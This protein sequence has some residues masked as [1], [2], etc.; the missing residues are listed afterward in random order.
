MAGHSSLVAGRLISK[1][2]Y[3]WGLLSQDE[4]ISTFAHQNLKV[5]TEALMGFS[6]EHSPEGHNTTL[7]PQFCA[8]MAA[9]SPGRHSECPWQGQGR[10]SQEPLIAQVQ[11]SGQPFV[12]FP[13][14]P[15]PTAS[16][17]LI[18]TTTNSPP[19][20]HTSHTFH[21]GFFRPF[22]EQ[23]KSTWI[24]ISQHLGKC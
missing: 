18:T 19:N 2:T 8:F 23:E 11:F 12:T 16:A 22:Q 9:S 4:W 3:L 6:H 5:F 15:P 17:K 20:T 7:L 13:Q 1:G 21:S 24:G 14:W 10:G